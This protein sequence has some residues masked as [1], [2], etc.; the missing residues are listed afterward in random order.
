[1]IVRMAKIMV[2]GP[3]DLL[4]DTLALLQG[5]GI[6]QVDADL[7]IEERTD[8]PAPALQLPDGGAVLQHQ[9]YEKLRRKIDELLTVLPEREGPVPEGAPRVSVNTLAEFIPDHLAAARK[10]RE[11]IDALAARGEELTR[12]RAFLAVL[13]RIVA[14]GELADDMEYAGFELPADRDLAEVQAC[15]NAAT[16]GRVVVQVVSAGEG[17]R[18]GVALTTG[19]QAGRVRTVLEECR[20]P[21]FQAPAGLGQA[22]VPER[23]AAV[24]S[25][26][27]ETRSRLA[28][29]LA[30]EQSFARQ[31][32]AEYLKAR[33]WLAR[34]L[35]LLQ[36][37][38]AVVKTR[39]CFFIHG[40]LAASDLLLLTGELERKFSGRVVVEEKEL[41]ERDFARI[42]TAL[43]N[44]AY[45]EPFELFTRLLPMPAYTSFDLTPFIG[46]FFPIF[47]GMMLGDVGYGLIL[48]VAAVVL[49]RRFSGRKNIRDG[50][51]ILF[52][53]A[54]YAVLF[55]WLYGECFGTVGHLFLGMEPVCFDRQTSLI[56]MLYFAVA[57]GVVHVLL[58]L[59]LGVIASL[60]LKMRKE[61]VFRLVN[62]LF[63]LGLCGLALSWFTP[64]MRLLREPLLFTLVIFIPVLLFTGGV[65]APLELLK[66]VGNIVSYARIMAVGLTSVLLAYVA[67]YMAG[68]MGSVWVG[69]LVALLLHMFNLVLGVF[70][71][72]IHSLRLHYVEFLTKFMEPGGKKFTPLGKR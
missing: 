51:K 35:S 2:M 25:R 67:N 63:I 13:A 43:H 57:A 8:D 38:A 3:R 7:P 64:S 34:R 42:P 29:L 44:P 70:A 54:L 1:M 15:L 17:R 4:L 21:W 47:F 32:Q 18:I 52:I 37:T 10:R 11:Q 24:D 49:V 5:L 39:M 6:M 48:L 16:D 62:I 50:G 60:R 14:G 61:A 33:Q 30:E 69:I 28:A 45:F 72:T 58:G 36:V 23:T 20:L 31:W 41:A 27:A 46:I 12:Y 19:E 65:M 53:S 66:N 22:T 71:P 56:P 59:V 55:G 68:R 40:W 9:Y 26:L